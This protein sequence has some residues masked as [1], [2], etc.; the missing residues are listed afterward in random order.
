MN[1]KL[2]I[3]ISVDILM[4]IILFIL[5]SYNYTG[6]KNHEIAGTAM[7]MLLILHHILNITWYKNLGRKKYNGARILQIAVNI[8]LLVD[9]LGLMISGIAMSRYMYTFIDLGISASF[10]RMIH[11]IFSY[12]GF[13]LMGFHIGLH[14]M[15]IIKMVGKMFGLEEK[16][17]L[18]TMILRC[19][20]TAIAG[21][22][23]Y[24]LEKRELLDYILQK[25]Q[26]PFFNNEES[27]IFFI[28]DY[29]AIM[30]LM[31]FISYYIQKIIIKIDKGMRQRRKHLK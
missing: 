24:A 10:S 16:Q 30:G 18:R 5:M 29:I 28:I 8:L 6:G 12:G 25:N 27:V 3:K 20:A 19:I 23:I 17:K 22:G 15:M 1:N 7:L 26:F 13:L 4:T 2:K 11:M 14:Y 21:Y 31:I 9:M